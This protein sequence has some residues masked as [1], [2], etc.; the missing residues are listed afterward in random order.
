MLAASPFTVICSPATTPSTA[1]CVAHR[2]VGRSSL[3]GVNRRS[4]KRAS[5]ASVQ[6]L[7]V[8]TDGANR[9]TS[10]KAIV[11][12]PFCLFFHILLITGWEH[13]ATAQSIAI[14]L[15]LGLAFHFGNLMGEVGLSRV[16]RQTPRRAKR[17]GPFLKE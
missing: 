1:S 17:P 15:C 11:H 12:S 10:V 16:S 9:W 4:D 6:R 5:L 13:P 14:R 8:K 2:P 3:F 7:R